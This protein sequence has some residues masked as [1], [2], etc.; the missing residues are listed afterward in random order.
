M[1][2]S[3]RQTPSAA[4]APTNPETVPIRKPLFS[5]VPELNDADLSSDSHRV[6]LAFASVADQPEEPL[7]IALRAN[8]ATPEE[9]ISLLA[10]TTT[11]HSSTQQLFTSTLDNPETRKTVTIIGD[12]PMVGDNSAGDTLI[13]GAQPL[14]TSLVDF[15]NIQTSEFSFPMLPE[16]SFLTTRDFNPVPPTDIALNA[17]GENPLILSQVV[18]P[19]PPFALNSATPNARQT[20]RLES[21]LDLL[22]N[23][24]I[25]A[26][27]ALLQA[28]GNR[29]PEVRGQLVDLE[30]MMQLNQLL[31]G[32]L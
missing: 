26:L 9:L 6:N 16:L 24:D 18:T 13:F 8:P 29:P 4:I 17:T 14:F 25:D 10:E 2:K 20:R 11:A 31:K 30:R 19:N 1:V 12:R 22:F 28:T 15:A 21:A 27:N 5:F 23:E 3:D 32:A 7:A